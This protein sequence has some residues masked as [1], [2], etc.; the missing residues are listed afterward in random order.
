MATFTFIVIRIVLFPITLT[1]YVWLVIRLILASR[2]T[3]ISAS[4]YSPLLSRLMMHEAG[5]RRD[6]AC[7]QAFKALPAVS[8]LALQM[9]MGPTLLAMRLSGVKLAAVTYPTPRPST[10]KTMVNHRTEFFDKA[11][12]DHLDRVKQVVILGAGW[13]TRAYNLPPAA[14][15]Q[16]FEVDMGGIQQIKREVL[17]KAGVDNGHVI[18][19]TTDFNKEAWVDSLKRHD[20]NPNLPTFFLWEGVT[21][22]LDAET[23][24][25]NLGAVG[26]ACASGSV[27]AFDYFSQEVIDGLGPLLLRYSVKLLQASGERLKFGVPT[28]APALEQISNLVGTHR[29]KVERYEPL[30][31]EGINEKPFGGL[32]VA[33][34]TP[35]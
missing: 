20:F 2:H 14:K 24:H 3:G 17:Q 16:V 4:A 21:Y 23:V 1:G 31:A 25:A 10:L 26:S 35:A 8:P 19:V 29:L 6:A 32:V 34:S 27:I 11:L 18:Y 15:V 12:F 9:F 7:K 30:G 13:D 5:T 22:Y 33:V 28:H